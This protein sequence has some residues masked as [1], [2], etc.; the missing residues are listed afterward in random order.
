MQFKDI[1]NY[2][3]M[4]HKS[5]KKKVFCQ[6]DTPLSK[7]MTFATEN[8][9][10]KT[11]LTKKKESR[12]VRGANAGEIAKEAKGFKEAHGKAD[13]TSVKTLVIPSCVLRAL[14]PSCPPSIPHSHRSV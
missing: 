12:N 1:F 10:T 11:H 13:N 7:K 8:Q 9:R 3:E 4:I 2:E 14:S 6:Y 5:V